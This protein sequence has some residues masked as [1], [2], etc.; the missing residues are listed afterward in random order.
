LITKAGWEWHSYYYLMVL[1]FRFS[2]I[3]QG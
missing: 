2:W 3:Q 1:I